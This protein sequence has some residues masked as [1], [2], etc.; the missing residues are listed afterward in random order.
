MFQHDSRANDVA[1]DFEYVSIWICQED[2][3]SSRY[4][5][6]MRRI[7]TKTRDD[8]DGFLNRHHFCQ[9]GMSESFQLIGYSVRHYF[10][11][12]SEA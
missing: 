2:N 6:A 9:W 12:I 11:N 3:A 10:V 1:C 4:I 8:F 5:P 7:K